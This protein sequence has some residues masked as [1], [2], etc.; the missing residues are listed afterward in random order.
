MPEFPIL[1]SLLLVPVALLLFMTRNFGRKIRHPHDLVVE[2]QG[3]RIAR[4]LFRSLRSRYDLLFDLAIA[5]VLTFALLDVGR[6][7]A[8][9]A[10][11]APAKGRRALVLDCSLS[12]FSG[13][14]GAR[15]IDAALAGIETRP[16][17]ADR[18]RFLLVF[19]PASRETR[20]LP[21]SAILRDASLSSK[22]ER[23]QA[24][25]R[26]L[27]GSP[28]FSVDYRA[29]ERL[30]TTGY[31]DIVLMT[32]SFPF[33]ARGFAVVE[34]GFAGPR[35]G[36]AQGGGLAG[37]PAVDDLAPEIWPSS[38]R[39]DRTRDAWTAVFVEAG[40]RTML[41]IGLFDE[42]GGNFAPLSNTR[43][44]I[45]DAREGR[46]VTLRTTGLARFVFADPE[47]GIPSTFTAVLAP[48]EIPAFASGG[49]SELILKALP[50][51]VARPRPEIALVD[52]D[53]R[54]D[55]RKA[56]AMTTFV[57]SLGKPAPY[58]ADPG[59][60][61]ARPLAAGFE[62]GVDFVWGDASLANPDLPL[63]YDARVRSASTPPFATEFPATG[64][65]PTSETGGAWLVATR[66]GTV[67][68]DAPSSE[69]FEP[70]KAGIVQL[71]IPPARTR[72][73][74]FLALLALGKLAAWKFLSRR[75]RRPIAA[76]DRPPG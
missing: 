49:F 8:T 33:E 23:E 10:D 50:Y 39:Y 30:V 70:A 15:P 58:L 66:S 52:A 69:R 2:R 42:A 36:L 57:T 56:G 55:G 63:A 61:G 46:T 22:S 28:L 3:P 67:A 47:G 74:L 31:R 14:P 5:L 35:R 41:S 7:L 24:A 76:E 51:L 64:G 48:P 65:R 34:T 1:F 21:W 59:L 40:R 62:R 9:P 11:A 18:D 68:V 73:A 16:G 4:F 44:T 32:D 54:D 12:M 71:A 26:L 6:G 37:A 27:S 29:L 43:Y 60:L 25:A 53:R 20:I 75:G 13:R 72:W 19:D 38:L 17:L 45:E